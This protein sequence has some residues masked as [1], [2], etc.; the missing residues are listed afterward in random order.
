MTGSRRG[1]VHVAFFG[2]VF[3]A[4]ATVRDAYEPVG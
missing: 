4:V 3:T 1:E 2:T